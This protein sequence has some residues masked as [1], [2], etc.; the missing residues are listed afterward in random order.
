MVCPMRRSGCGGPCWGSMRTP[1]AF[2]LAHKPLK[3]RCTS[4]R[5]VRMFTMRMVVVALALGVLAR[6]AAADGLPAMK[7]RAVAVLDARTGAEIFGKKA[8][9]IR[10]IASTTKIF[11]A[12]VARKR[13]L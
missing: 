13:G 11:V 12:M 1:R 7:S 8:D 10:P 3:S 9:E 2:I 6:P 4:S 5:H